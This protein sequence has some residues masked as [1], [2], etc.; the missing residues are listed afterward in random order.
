LGDVILIWTSLQSPPAI[1]LLVVDRQRKQV[2]KNN[3]IHVR[4]NIQIINKWKANNVFTLACK[5]SNIFIQKSPSWNVA[6]PVRVVQVIIQFIWRNTLGRANPK[7][8]TDLRRCPSCSG[9]QRLK[10]AYPHGDRN[11][12]KLP[13][14]QKYIIHFKILTPWNNQHIHPQFPSLT[15][16]KLFE[17]SN[18]YVS[19]NAIFKNETTL[20]AQPHKL[21][22]LSV[23]L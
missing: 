5:G 1:N 18:P 23:Y 16:F 15:S 11:D 22:G 14:E 12:P 17:V 10:Y 9:R 2:P 19:H 13:W 20:L 21:Y 6:R 8:T 3:P 4:D 7:A